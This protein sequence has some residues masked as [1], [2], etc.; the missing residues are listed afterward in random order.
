[1]LCVK[2][3]VYLFQDNFPRK[4]KAQDVLAGI[5]VLLEVEVRCVG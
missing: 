5:V 1:M 3:R 4:R 2:I